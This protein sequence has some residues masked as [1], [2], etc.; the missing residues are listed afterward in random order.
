MTTIP[1]LTRLA[2][3]LFS[4]CPN[5]ASCERLFSSYGQIL[6]DKRTTMLPSRMND[7]A[8]LKMHLRQHYQEDGQRGRL[9]EK[10]K[11][12]LDNSNSLRLSARSDSRN[13]SRDTSRDSSQAVRPTS[14]R[15]SSRRSSGAYDFPPSGIETESMEAGNDETSSMSQQFGNF[16]DQLSEASEQDRPQPNQ[17]APEAAI[18]SPD[19]TFEYR[20]ISLS[21]LFNYHAPFWEKRDD[22]RSSLNEE[23]DILDYFEETNF[24]DSSGNSRAPAYDLD[25]LTSSNV[26]Y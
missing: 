14:S 15:P 5:S 26:L 22:T 19:F 7:M 10:A 20:P 13:T 18:I 11:R 9:M 3:Y 12:H 4:I 24:T 21:S 23:R 1:A 6:S 25:G 16:F 2:I 17:L 8:E